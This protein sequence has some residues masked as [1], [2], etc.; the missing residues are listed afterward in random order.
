MISLA[1]KAISKASSV[2]YLPHIHPRYSL[3]I[4][5]TYPNLHRFSLPP[6]LPPLSTSHATN[7]RKCHF[8]FLH[9]ARVLK[10]RSHVGIHV[11]ECV[12]LSLKHAKEM[13]HVYIDSLCYRYCPPL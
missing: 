10:S 11:C 6:P 4:L 8:N 7:A 2:F 9:C 5:T 3:F 1:F 12:C 13:V